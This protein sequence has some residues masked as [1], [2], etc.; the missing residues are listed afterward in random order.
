MPSRGSVQQPVRFFDLLSAVQET[1]ADHV[2]SVWQGAAGVAAAERTTQSLVSVITRTAC[3]I[4]QVC[5]GRGVS[6]AAVFASGCLE[7]A[8]LYHALW[9][10]G[11]TVISIPSTQPSRQIVAQ[12]NNSDADIL[13]H[14]SEQSMRLAAILPQLTSVKHRIVL[15]N[16]GSGSRKGGEEVSYLHELKRIPSEVSAT[17]TLSEFSEHR[18]RPGVPALV[19]FTTDDP[20]E[21]HGVAFSEEALL[22]AA[23]L[24]SQLYPPLKGG[25][26]RRAWF[27]MHDKSLIRLLHT[28]LLPLVSS[29]AVCEADSSLSFDGYPSFVQS[30]RVSTIVVDDAHLELCRGC[31]SELSPEVKRELEVVFL[32]SAPVPKGRVK[33]L[34]S[35]LVPVYGRAEMG[36]IVAAGHKGAAYFCSQGNPLGLELLSCGHPLGGVKLSVVQEDGVLISNSQVGELV[37]TSAQNMLSYHGSRPGDAYLGPRNGLHSGDIGYWSFDAQGM[38]HL[39][40]T[41]RSSAAVE[42]SGVSVYV[43]DVELAMYAINGVEAARVVAFPHLL[44]GR[45]VA[46]YI[47][48]SRGASVT[49]ATVWEALSKQ[50]SWPHIPKIVLFGHE[51]ER[52]P[53]PSQAA[54]LE[55]LQ[56]FESTEFPEGMRA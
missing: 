13:I 21:S 9:L 1:R 26:G 18:F 30:Q 29:I 42:R 56:S 17:N 27:L 51:D 33:A 11:I 12:I 52:L 55:T 40:I 48:V 47:M 28:T 19:V 53:L 45:E 54:L 22:H 49:R 36:G 37:A 46:A 4:R 35:V 3:A 6:R 10:L 32:S 43:S 25:Q 24:Q 38:P 50:F 31:V 23:C 2:I 41:G 8:P 44:Y 14:G 16:V 34:Q 7:L 5:E 20:I 15:A 39:V